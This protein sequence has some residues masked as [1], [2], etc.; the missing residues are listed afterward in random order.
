[1]PQS[2]TP[3]VRSIVQPAMHPGIAA[4]RIV[5]LPGAYNAAQEFQDAG[6][7]TAVSQ[8]RAPVD[9]VYVDLELRHVGDR[10]ALGHLRTEI[11]LPARAAGV[12]VWL[13]GISLGGLFALD[14]AADYPDDLDG[15]CLL[16]PYLGNRMLTGEI[17]AA[18][19]LKAWNPGALADTDEERRI[20]R[21]IKGR[22]QHSQPLYLGY[23]RADRFAAAHALLAA[24]LPVDSV[25]VIDGGHEWRTWTAL[26]ENFLDSRFS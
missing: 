17:A 23:G 16:A 8:R 1:M 26:W 7:S 19:G 2:W 9:L 22:A 4:T 3:Q 12:S 5:W 15:L 14:Y 25:D 10:S 21:Y 6:F 18:P 24:T 13:A 20:W 11:I